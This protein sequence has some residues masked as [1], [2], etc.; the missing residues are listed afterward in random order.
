MSK[1]QPAHGWWKKEKTSRNE[2]KNQKKRLFFR[3]CVSYC[4][5]S[6]DKRHISWYNKEKNHVL[7]HVVNPQISQNMEEL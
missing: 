6:V 4:A 3:R 1:N 7:A 2:P 5:K